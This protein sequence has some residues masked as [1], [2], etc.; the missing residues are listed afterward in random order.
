MPDQTAYGMQCNCLQKMDA[1]LA[2][3]KCRV[4]RTIIFVAQPPATY[5]VPRI[6]I[7]RTG[8]APPPRRGIDPTLATPNFCPFCGAAIKH[9]PQPQ[10]KQGATP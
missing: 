2:A 3:A 7:S 9:A 10:P 8:A 6:Q 5:E 1:R 4:T